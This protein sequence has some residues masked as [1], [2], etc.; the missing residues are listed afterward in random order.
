MYNVD[1]DKLQ[2]RVFDWIRF[3]LIICIVFLHSTP[4]YI[5]GPDADEASVIGLEVNFDSFFIYTKILLQEVLT[6]FAVP[7][8]FFIS[9]YL[10]FYSNKKFDFSIYKYKLSRR[11]QSLLLPYLIWNTIA[12][13]YPISLYFFRN[14]SLPNNI[15]DWLLYYW[16]AD[17]IYNLPIN[18][19]LW[20]IRDLMVA[21]LLSPI[22]YFL[23]YR[24]GWLFI[25]ILTG[26]YVSKLC[27]S[28]IGFG[29]YVSY[30][31]TLGAF[32]SIKGYNILK[33]FGKIEYVNYLFTLAL[34]CL[35]MVC[36]GKHQE[37]FSSAL[38]F[39][40]VSSLIT[41]FNLSGHVF[42]QVSEKAALFMDY[43]KERVFFIYVTHTLVFIIIF[44]IIVKKITMNIPN[45]FLFLIY[46]IMPF[47]K[48]FICILI[49]NY[50]KKT[51]P[52]LLQILNGGKL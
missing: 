22:I 42:K 16:D 40:C 44:D 18:Y 23:C 47:I 50:L 33:V 43:L 27:P 29:N 46:L 24:G 2:L 14:V 35:R 32:L 17:D 10:F 30:F 15:V 39:Y 19:P 38:P 11:I 34:L 7:G 28:Y 36:Y 25:I 26:A 31:F 21:T 51:T 49:F 12:I 9:G 20:Y 3:P 6:K 8:F 52:K 41:I 45:I 37:L 1:I 4:G 48:I 13:S 5:V